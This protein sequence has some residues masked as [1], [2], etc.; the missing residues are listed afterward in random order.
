[1]KLDNVEGTLQDA[2]KQI[3][4][5]T[6]QP[7]A[8]IQAERVTDENLRHRCFYVPEGTLYYRGEGREIKPDGNVMLA[9]TRE[10]DNL[11]L[12]H[13][14][15]AVE[16]DNSFVQLRRSNDYLPRIEEA[17]A[18]IN[19]SETVIVDLSKVRLQGNHSMLRYLEI[20]TSPEDYVKLNDEERKLA[21]MYHGSMAP[22]ADK[23][24]KSDFDLSMATL[25]KFNIGSTRI[26]VVAPDYVVKHVSKQKPVIARAS[27]LVNFNGNSDVDAGDRA[28]DYLQVRG[29]RRVKKST[30]GD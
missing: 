7:S 16:A 1:M 21:A 20:G 19:A 4:A 18:S 14:E 11:V 13:L 3:V 27:V 22:K 26:Y 29:E 6:M 30:L 23:M 15:D 9:I 12:R 28:F 10:K 25:H 17:V 2:Y 5:G 8:K 24:L